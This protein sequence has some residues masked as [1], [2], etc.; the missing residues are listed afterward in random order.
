MSAR[1]NVLADSYWIL[2]FTFYHSM[3]TANGK[4]M[5]GAYKKKHHQ[6]R[7]L[8]VLVLETF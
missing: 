5:P 6:K 8:L 1:F 7:K 4:F 2:V 3:K